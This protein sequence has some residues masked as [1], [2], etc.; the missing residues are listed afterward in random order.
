MRT[1]TLSDAKSHKFWNI[2]LQG[3]SFTVTYGRQGTAG[4]TQTKKFPDAA[5]AQSG[6]IGILRDPDKSVRA[7]AVRGLCAVGG[8]ADA[9][10]QAVIERLEDEAA[11]VRIAAIDELRLIGP[12]AK[13][14]IP[15]LTAATRD[16]RAAVR[17]A[18][19]EALKRVKGS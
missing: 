4:Q 16:N 5:K 9:V 11:E 18:A 2:E 1:F 15:A 10:I 12:D 14:A 17:E 8:H 13:A 7:Q 19:V 6:L 3:Q